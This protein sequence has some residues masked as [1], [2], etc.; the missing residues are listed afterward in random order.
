MRRI[1]KEREREEK[2]RRKD[3]DRNERR[4]T[5]INII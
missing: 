1:V 5:G 2:K 4:E 3:F